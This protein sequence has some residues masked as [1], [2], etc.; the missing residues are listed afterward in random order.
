VEREEKDVLTLV[1]LLAEYTE[2]KCCT[3]NYLLLIFR[4][5]WLTPG[6]PK[7]SG[8][9]LASCPSNGSK[10]I[11]SEVVKHLKVIKIRRFCSKCCLQRTFYIYS[12]FVDYQ[13]PSSN[14]TREN[15]IVSSYF[16]FFYSIF[17]G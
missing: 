3:C 6:D 8:T 2:I 11:C 10:S 17:A 7:L 13:K 1:K 16:L 14:E 5:E 12:I 9:S 15:T 4:T